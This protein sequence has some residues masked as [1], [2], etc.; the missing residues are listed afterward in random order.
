MN[1]T[2]TVKL[3]DNDKMLMY[4]G[5]DVVEK[6]DLVRQVNA[7]FMASEFLYLGAI[8]VRRSEVE[9]ISINEEAVVL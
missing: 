3:I 9:W 8:V 2:V 5:E 7:T 6:E 1:K 4:Q